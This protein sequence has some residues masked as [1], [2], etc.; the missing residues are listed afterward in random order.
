M[1]F[2]F[3]PRNLKIGLVSGAVVGVL[4]AACGGASPTPTPAPVVQ[5]PT[6]APSP[7]ATP[8]QQA[9]EV[10]GSGIEGG[11]PEFSRGALVWQ[12]YWLS[13]DHFGPFVM[14][15]GA[16]IPF[17][18]PMDM[19]QAAMQM[20]GQNPNDRIVVPQNMA[21]LQAVYKSG[22]PALANDPMK[23]DPMDFH[24]MRLKPETFD[25]TVSVRGQ[26]ET[27]L[28]ESQWAHNFANP[29]FGTPTSDFGAQQRFMGVMVNMLAQMQAQYAMKVLMGPDGLYRDSDGTLDYA[30]NW[31]M[32]HALSDIAGLAASG[33]YMNPDM[34]PMFDKLATD[35]MNALASRAPEDA[36]EA[37]AAIR[38]LAYRASTAQN[39]DVKKAALDRASEIAESLKTRS[40]V[41]VV[42][43]AAAVA[44]LIAAGSGLGEDDYIAATNGVLARLLGDFDPKYGVFN[45]KDTY[46][47]DDVAWII[48]GFSSAFQRG[49]EAAREGAGRALHAFYEATI[50]LA[51]MQL[52]APPGKD[53]AMAGEWEKNLPAPVFYHPANTPPPPM[54]GKLT[55]PAEEI[56]WDGKSWKVTSDRFVAGGAMHLANELNWIG[57]H[58]GSIPFPES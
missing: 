24:G 43:E 17:E 10:Q 39:Q 58:L 32:L 26:A 51:G 21:P 28:K 25:T 29:H 48:G 3:T 36:R 53:G 13:R 44:G 19:L 38:A 50:S 33:P 8:T 6:L 49:P 37:A 55:V 4:A 1:L 47:A 11:D 20:V 5:A 57:P 31:V 40:S 18:P 56:K 12:A 7:T 34:V 45:S 2:R 22:S 41:D 9:P 42:E 46:S 52:S 15:S 54:A 14:A 23:F 27:M 35:L 16:G 30:G